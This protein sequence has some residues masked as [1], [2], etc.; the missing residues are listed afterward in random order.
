MESDQAVECEALHEIHSKCSIHCILWS[1]NTKPYLAFPLSPAKLLLGICVLSITFQLQSLRAL[2]EAAP[3]LELGKSYDYSLG[4]NFL[5]MMD[6]AIKQVYRRWRLIQFTL[7]VLLSTFSSSFVSFWLLPR[8][9]SQLS[10]VLLDSA[11][12]FTLLGVGGLFSRGSLDFEGLYQPVDVNN[13]V[14][15]VWN[16]GLVSELDRSNL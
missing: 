8:T 4:L 10:L 7:S 1:V 13:L 15:V 2:Q 6:P 16:Q 14:H 9:F 12:P 5:T 3:V 11:L